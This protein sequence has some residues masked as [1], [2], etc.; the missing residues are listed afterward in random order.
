MVGVK[1]LLI[2]MFGWIRKENGINNI[3]EKLEENILLICKITL[4]L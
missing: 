4:F 3:Q 1:I 2:L